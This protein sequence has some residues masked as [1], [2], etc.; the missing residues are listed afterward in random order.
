MIK[1]TKHLMAGAGFSWAALLVATIRLVSEAHSWPM[2]AEAGQ[3]SQP[4]VL[5][6]DDQYGNT[7]LHKAV[8]IE[9]LEAISDLL[10]AGADLEARNQNGLT[11]LHYAAIGGDFE[12]ISTLLAAGADLEARDQDGLTPLH[13]AASGGSP[14]VITT[15]L[16]AGADLRAQAQVDVTP[17]H[18]AASGGSPEAITTLLAAGAD[19]LARDM[20]G[21]RPIDWVGE[22]SSLY[23]TAAYWQLND[24]TLNSQ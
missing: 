3:S 11:P 13:Y 22:D 5:V 21:R 1:L 16:A 6:A 2:K 9:N 14:E 8:V 23:D 19:P 10:A 18:I 20:G 4:L 7:P 17:L 12:V 15:L 24:A